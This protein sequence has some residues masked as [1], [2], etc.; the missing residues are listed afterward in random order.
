MALSKKVADLV[1]RKDEVRGLMLLG[2]DFNLLDAGADSIQMNSAPALLESIWPFKSPLASSGALGRGS[3]ILHIRSILELCGQVMRNLMI[4]TAFEN[5]NSA[6][7]S[8]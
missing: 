4:A 7:K 8:S 6:N 3:V 5:T 1:A 2:H